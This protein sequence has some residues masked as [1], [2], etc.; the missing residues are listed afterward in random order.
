[1]AASKKN[2]AKK[3]GNG[4]RS[5]PRLSGKDDKKVKDQADELAKLKAELA[6]KD[7]ELK[8]TLLQASKNAPKKSRRD[9]KNDETVI[10]IKD[11]IRKEGWR[12]TKFI[13]SDNQT[14]LMAEA[15]LDDRGMFA[16]ANEARAKRLRAQFFEDYERDINIQLNDVRQYVQSRMREVAMAYMAQH[17][18][19]NLPQKGTIYACI[20]RTLDL[21]DEAKA[22]IAKWYWDDLLPRATGNAACWK[23]SMRH[24]ETISL[25]TIGTVDWEN[26]PEKISLHVPPSTEAIC[27]VIYDSCR[28]RWINQFKWDKAHPGFAMALVWKQGK[29]QEEVDRITAESEKILSKKPVKMPKKKKPSVK[30][31][32]EPDFATLYTRP[33]IGAQKH[34]GWTEEGINKFKTVTK[35]N[36][37]IRGSDKCNAWEEKV[38]ELVRADYDE[39]Y[40]Q[41]GEAP[42][43]E[44][45]AEEGDAAKAFEEIELEMED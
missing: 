8:R 37:D 31:F 25:A 22:A 30:V 10:Q 19:D 39:E 26:P 38:L 15:F 6:E 14:N 45:P 18:A 33:V 32:Q 36:R 4:E 24:H 3:A 27:G 41:G 34:G 11:W 9:A 42:V 12:R 1:M 29:P 2:G 23:D 13:T 17:G 16:E 7:K 20:N 35:S 43:V 40:L 44:E 28:T 21:T 5:S